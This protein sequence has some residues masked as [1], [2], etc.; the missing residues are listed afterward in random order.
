MASRA[1]KCRAPWEEKKKKIVVNE[2]RA[3]RTLVADAA[4]ATISY[5]SGGGFVQHLAGRKIKLG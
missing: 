2:N 5:R 3:W 1:T 4:A